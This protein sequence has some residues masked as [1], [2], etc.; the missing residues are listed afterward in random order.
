MKKFVF[1]L[2]LIYS[3]NMAWAQTFPHPAPGFADN[4][5]FRLQHGP[6]STQRSLSGRVLYAPDGKLMVI[7]AVVSESNEGDVLSYRSMAKIS[8]L[9]SDGT[10]DLSFG[11]GGTFWYNPGFD[12][13]SVYLH[14]F[15]D[16]ITSPIGSIAMAGLISYG[17]IIDAQGNV[18]NFSSA[19]PHC[20]ELG[21][22]AVSFQADG[23][24]LLGVYDS[25]VE[26]AYLFRLKP[27]GSLDENF[28]DNGKL[29]ITF[30]DKGIADIKVSDGGKIVLRFVAE[31][32]EKT[33]L[34]NYEAFVRILPDNTL[35][36]TFGDGGVLEPN[37]VLYSDYNFNFELDGDRIVGIGNDFI[38]RYLPD[39]S[40]DY[41]FGNFGKVFVGFNVD[42]FYSRIALQP[43]GKII[44]YGQKT[45][46][47]PILRRFDEYGDSDTA[48]DNRAT[49]LLAQ[50]NLKNISVALDGNG[51]IALL[52]YNE[53]DNSDN[54]IV[55]RLD[56]DGF[57][58]TSYGINGQSATPYSPENSKAYDLERQPSDN[59]IV[60]LGNLDH[61][62]M[63][64]TRLLP[65]GQPDMSF[66][67]Q[68]TVWKPATTNDPETWSSLAL[69][70]GGG[71]LA[72]GEVH[73][74]WGKNE[75]L[76]RLFTSNGGPDPA[77][78]NNGEVFLKNV[79]GLR[80]MAVLPSGKIR[81]ATVHSSIS[82][83][84]GFLPNG[85]A[86]PAFGNGGHVEFVEHTD[87]I[88]IIARPDDMCLVVWQNTDDIWQMIRTKPN[89]TP[90][91]AFGLKTLD[92]VGVSLVG[93]HPQLYA[94]GRIL[95]NGL[96]NN[97]PTLIR[98]NADGTPD[99]SFGSA[100]R[101]VFPD[102][103]AHIV[104]MR[105]EPDGRISLT[106]DATDCAAMT[107]FLNP[108]FA[109]LLENGQF[110][111][112]F[113]V[114]GL[115]YH[116]INNLQNLHSSAIWN[117][118]GDEVLLAG[119][120]SGFSVNFGVAKFGFSTVSASTSPA[121]NPLQ[122]RI[123]PN[124]VDDSGGM[125]EYV[126]SKAGYVNIHV[127]DVQGRLMASSGSDEFRTAGQHQDPILGTSSLLPGVYWV[128]IS[129]QHN[130]MA[131]KMVRL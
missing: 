130:S 12:F 85:Q 40:I 30:T 127:Y 37:P 60:T 2:A 76:L 4:G 64:L 120:F 111:P 70:P 105:M 126:L 81:V 91:P 35:D 34:D 71:I 54:A 98:L 47:Q 14:L 84:R 104:S 44:L 43:D 107:P 11:N 20:S 23:K 32:D 61:R 45:N 22:Y 78:G 19:I 52:G 106:G 103:W 57:L 73:D 39:G 72:A 101:V 15:E 69:L 129:D 31:N 131:L 3:L 109:R 51:A 28:F 13:F 36:Q 62:G 118:G 27:D 41:D 58:D 117:E 50:E 65:S 42:L 66:G 56:V 87:R 102:N 55:Y 116:A 24:L 88:Q 80:H 83:I 68:G 46:D 119:R 125:L 53:D 113:G 26:H 115:A 33:H 8:R 67:D 10:P 97:V 94:D 74:F 93:I 29:P 110:D 16:A 121:A 17:L 92:L 99:A 7:E 25:E 75:V 79:G 59:K 48:F 82:A 49:L 6:D 96:V 123:S 90:D 95:I 5:V 21:T 108:A 114:D 38:F 9:K 122:A 1:S 128:T 18:Q 100:G 89:G 112:G 124:P 77:F 63:L 86:D